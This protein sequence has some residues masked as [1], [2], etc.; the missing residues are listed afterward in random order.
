METREGNT[1]LH[2]AA[3]TKDTTKLSRLLAEQQ[4]DPNPQ[5]KKGDIRSHTAGRQDY[6]AA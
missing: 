5:N 1:P 3:G 6:P 2:I 4:C